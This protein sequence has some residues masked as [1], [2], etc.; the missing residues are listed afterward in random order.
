MGVL[1]SIIIPV[2]NVES[3]LEECLVSVVNQNFS[4]F[5]IILVNDGSTDNSFEICASYR[6]KYD[7]I[8]LISQS[9]K[10]LAAARN[11]GISISKGEYITFLDSDDYLD[12]N[13]CAVMYGIIS[14]HNVDMVICQRA[15]FDDITKQTD[16]KI[17]KDEF[18]NRVI[19]TTE[20]L[21]IF[22]SGYIELLSAYAKLFRRNLLLDN[23]IWYPEGFLYEDGVPTLEMIKACS[24]FFITQN[25]LHFRRLRGDSITGREIFCEKNI[26]DRFF[27]Y[28]KQMELYNTINSNIISNKY[29]ELQMRFYSE[30]L[31]H[32]YLK[33]QYYAFLSFLISDTLP[34]N[35][36]IFIFGASSAGAKNV[37]M[38]DTGANS[39]FFV[40]NDKHKQGKKFLGHPVISLDELKQRFVHNHSNRLFITSVF[41]LEIL[42]Q[43]LYSNIIA[44]IDDVFPYK[45]K[46]P[47]EKAYKR[48]I[49]NLIIFYNKYS[50]LRKE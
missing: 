49:L 27:Q 46:T 5:E 21:Q 14:K 47:S 48:G 25:V 15:D 41:Y 39:V 10:G 2:Y 34:K 11:T 8:K 38:L 50:Y 16:I 4:D 13:Y 32:S 33:Y 37:T 40:D 22:S 20:M 23:N 17:F 43:L 12:V 44:E 24:K 36:N 1:L 31:I 6:K 18:S 9:N 28:T 30:C 45:A 29:K 42:Q 26:S 7:I 3:Y 35:I 19:N